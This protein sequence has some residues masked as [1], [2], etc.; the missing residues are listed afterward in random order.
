MDLAPVPSAA[1]RRG[2]IRELVSAHFGG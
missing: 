1:G 2:A